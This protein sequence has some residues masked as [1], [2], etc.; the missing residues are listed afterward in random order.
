MTTKELIKLVEAHEGE[1]YFK[2]TGTPYI[3]AFRHDQKWVVEIHDGID[4]DVVEI[5][6]VGGRWWVVRDLYESEKPLIEDATEWSEDE[7][8]PFDFFGDIEIAG[9]KLILI[10]YDED[11]DGYLFEVAR[12]ELPISEL[13]KAVF[14]NPPLNWDG[15]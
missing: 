13:P 4:K 7:L 11:Y 14:Y 15:K 2:I 5:F 3:W 1:P 9:D 8:A 6:K 10:E 12:Q